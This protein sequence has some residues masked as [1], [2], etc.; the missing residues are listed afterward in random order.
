MT[1]LAFKVRYRH[2]A[3]DL[4]SESLEFLD[5]YGNVVVLVAHFLL[6]RWQA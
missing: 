1:Y 2:S 5:A 6:C 3:W 4:R